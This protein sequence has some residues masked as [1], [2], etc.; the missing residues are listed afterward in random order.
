ME[1]KKINIIGVDYDVD[2]SD[3]NKQPD[4]TLL[5]KFVANEKKENMRITY[6][7]KYGAQKRQMAMRAWLLKK[8]Y[9]NIST[10][11]RDNTL[12]I[13]KR[14]EEYNDEQS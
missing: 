8:G 2:T 14:K 1:S 9:L 13:I 4:I 5:E 12:T 10:H 6:E 11:V 7:D 3:M